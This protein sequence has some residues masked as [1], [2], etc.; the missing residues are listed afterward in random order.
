MLCRYICT[1]VGVLSGLYQRVCTMGCL[2]VR[3]V[4]FVSVVCGVMF[5]VCDALVVLFYA[6]APL[7]FC[8]LAMRVLVFGM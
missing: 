7:G 8:L 3:C 1:I 4:R 2:V 5:F 6:R